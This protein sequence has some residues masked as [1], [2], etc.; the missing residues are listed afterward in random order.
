MCYVQKRQPVSIISVLEKMRQ[1]QTEPYLCVAE[2]NEEY[3]VKGLG[4][5]RRSQISEWICANL[6]LRLGLPIADFTLV[7]V[8]VELYEEL[9][10]TSFKDIGSGIAFGSKKVQASNWFEGRSLGLVDEE[11]QR[12]ILVFDLWIKNMDRTRINPNLLYQAEPNRLI[13]IDHN[14]AFD[15]DFVL[16]DFLET[17]LFADR[18]TEIAYD[19]VKRMEMEDWL[20]TALVALDEICN[21][22]PLEWEWSNMECDIP[23]S[24]DFDFM[25]QVLGRCAVRGALWEDK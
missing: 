11:L 16:R 13:I 22:L 1:G 20:Q 23:A 21:N 18:F 8:P 6:A 10:D 3:I 17:H 25:R 7:D 9:E 24:Y 19:L 14:L 15:Q 4:A 5:T 12:K 2:N